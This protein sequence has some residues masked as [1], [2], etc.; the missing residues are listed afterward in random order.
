MNPWVILIVLVIL[1]ITHAGAFL[2]GR[3]Y[4][5]TKQKA[6]QVDAV[7]K[8]IGEHNA[9]AQV[10]MLAAYEAGQAQSRAR[11]VT[12]TVQQQ[13]DRLVET[14]VYRDCRLDDNGLRL[15]N[16]AN[17]GRIEAPAPGK[18]DSALSGAPAIKL[19]DIR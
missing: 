4:E 6:A 14:T 12:R 11:V 5:E 16:Q 10:D 9:N 2:K 7:N 15:W 3:G 17:A 18:P 1:G 19:P 13:V 8:A